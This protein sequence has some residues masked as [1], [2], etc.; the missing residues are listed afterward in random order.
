MRA[1]RYY[2]RAMSNL[3]YGW[4][5]ITRITDIRGEV[6]AGSSEWLFKSPLAGA[7]AWWVAQLQAGQLIP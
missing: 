2:V 7:G 1:A 3:V 5:T 4:S 6:Q